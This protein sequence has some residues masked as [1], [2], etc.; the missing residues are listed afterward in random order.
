MLMPSTQGVSPVKVRGSRQASL[1]G[2]YM[3]AV[4]QYLRTGETKGLAK[5]KGKSIAGQRLITDQ[6]TLTS[7]AQAGSIQLDSIYAVP[8]SSS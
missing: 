3:S 4:G 6:Q 7:L 1:L 5:F 2:R 8:D